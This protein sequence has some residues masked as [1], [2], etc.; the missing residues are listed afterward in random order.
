VVYAVPGVAVAVAPP[1]SFDL[2]SV[3]VS[4]SKHDV[5]PKGPSKGDWSATSDRLLNPVAQFGRPAGAVVGSDQARATATSKTTY[6]VKGTVTL[7]G[8]TLILG[9]PV[10]PRPGGGAIFQVTGGTGIFAHAHAPKPSSAP[11]RSR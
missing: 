10:R 4:V 1:R 2:R 5:S 6:S 8:G 3:T 11:A 7:P 9:G